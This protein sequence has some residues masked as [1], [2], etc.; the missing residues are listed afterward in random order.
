MEIRFRRDSE[1]EC[2]RRWAPIVEKHDFVEK[3]LSWERPAGGVY[4]FRRGL[5]TVHTL[6]SVAM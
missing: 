2:R 3:R 6:A 5:V 1:A 4:R